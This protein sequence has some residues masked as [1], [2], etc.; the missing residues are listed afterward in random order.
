MTRALFDRMQFD[1]NGKHSDGDMI[2]FITSR[3]I[4]DFKTIKSY[5]EAWDKFYA[6]CIATD[7]KER[8]KT[9]AKKS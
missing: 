1:Y 9:Y 8:G 5:Q 3:V 4:A 2:R 6:I 7:F